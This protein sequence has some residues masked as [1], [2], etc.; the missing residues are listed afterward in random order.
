VIYI[1]GE[2]SPTE[3]DSNLEPTADHIGVERKA[4]LLAASQPKAF[5]ASESGGLK[6]A[7]ADIFSPAISEPPSPPISRESPPFEVEKI[8]GDEDEMLG[9]GLRHRLVTGEE[10]EGN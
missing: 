6:L 10:E 5:Y 9:Q 7:G 8:E 3:S 2:R 1:N 4:V